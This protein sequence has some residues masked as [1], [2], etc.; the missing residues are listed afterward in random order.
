[1]SYNEIYNSATD[2]NKVRDYLLKLVDVVATTHGPQGRLVMTKTGAT[3]DGVSVI[4][5]CNI[6]NKFGQFSQS[7]V[8]QVA[9][10]TNDIVGDG[11]TTACVLLGSLIRN[12]MKYSKINPRRLQEGM[13]KSVAIVKKSLESQKKSIP[14]KVEPMSKIASMSANGDTE[15][16]ANIAKAIEAV[17]KDGIVTIEESK[18][19]DTTMEIVSGMRFDRGFVSP[20]FAMNSKKKGHIELDSPYILICNQ[21]VTNLAQIL[22]VLEG[23]AGSGKPLLIIAEDVEGDALSALILNHLSNKI[24]VC[25]VKAPGFGDR[26]LEML[27]DIA[28][29]TNTKVIDGNNVELKDATIDYLGHAG[30]VHIT[31]D[32]TTIVDCN[33]NKENLENRLTAIRDEIKESTSDYEKEKLQER[34]AKL[35][36]AVAAIRVGGA[37]EIEVKERKDRFDD[38]LYA[39]QA[40]V[41]SGIVVGGGSALLYAYNELKSKVH[42]EEDDDTKISMKIVLETLKAP[43]T[44]IL[45]NAGFEASVVINKLINDGKTDVAFDV[46]LGNSNCTDCSDAKYYVNANEA[47]IMDPLKVVLTALNSAVSIASI[48]LT[49]SSMIIPDEEET[50]SGNAAG[51]MGGMNPYGGMGGMDY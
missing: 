40:A 36:G 11:T 22:T 15:I 16:G 12:G 7:Y 5:E 14:I 47:G 41:E 13:K 44:Q 17:G 4:K 3:K 46:N 45:H 1:M 49:S 27:E 38:S 48:I 51:G 30:K 35:N 24:K 26:R 2:I 10:Q 28:I 8:K 34:L 20:C 50:T 21:K 37:T 31:K 9:N 23:V 29:L 33:T 42:H 43:I 39:T 25:S 19:S 32:H 18:S 6:K